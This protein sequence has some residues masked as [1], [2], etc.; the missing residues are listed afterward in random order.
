[1]FV[2]M[3]LM[4]LG[5]SCLLP[6]AKHFL[7]QMTCGT[8]HRLPLGLLQ[9]GGGVMAQCFS[10]AMEGITTVSLLQSSSGIPHACYYGKA[11]AQQV[12]KREDRQASS[13]NR[14]ETSNAYVSPLPSKNTASSP[15]LAG[16]MVVDAQIPWKHPRLYSPSFRILH[17]R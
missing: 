12:T 5:S 13:R 3:V 6:S 7:E 2:D 8:L 4:K 10:E 14:H 11:M 9:I 17:T 15:P 16:R 1:M